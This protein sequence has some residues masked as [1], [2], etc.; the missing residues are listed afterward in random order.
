MSNKE[1]AT[2]AIRSEGFQLIRIRNEKKN[3]FE[4]KMQDIKEASIYLLVRIAFSGNS[5]KQFIECLCA[6]INFGVYLS[7]AKLC[8]IGVWFHLNISSWRSFGGMW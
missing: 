6:Q 2:P 1:A 3:L 5:I 8:I 7:G 4:S